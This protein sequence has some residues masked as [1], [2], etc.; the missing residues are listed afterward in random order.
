MRLESLDGTTN[1]VVSIAGYEFP[2]DL[3]ELHTAN[4]LEADLDVQTLHGRGTCRTACMMTWD[5][6][7][8]ADWLEA[9]GTQQV[10]TP[11]MMGFPEPNLQMQVT[12]Q[13]LR[14]IR[15]HVYFILESPGYW[16]MDDAQEGNRYYIGGVD[17]TVRRAA[18]LAAAESLRSELQNFP[19]RTP[20]T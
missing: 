16:K 20:K 1:L 6:A 13:A 18:L 7:R 19:V 12:G 2:D 3:S 11:T 5:A 10:G 17:I 9:L 8:F 15:F 14:Y 4:W